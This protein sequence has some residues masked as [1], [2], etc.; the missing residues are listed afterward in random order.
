MTDWET[1]VLL[2]F[3]RNGDKGNYNNHRDLSLI[4]VT[5]RNFAALLLKK[6]QTLRSIQSRFSEGFRPVRDCID[7]IFNFLRVLEQRCCRKQSTASLTSQWRLIQLAVGRRGEYW[8]VIT[9]LINCSSQVRQTRI[10]INAESHPE[11]SPLRVVDTRRLKIVVDECLINILH[12]CDAD[13]INCPG[14]KIRW[15]LDES[16]SK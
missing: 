10:R 15:E 11:T 5:V 8:R 16:K 1:A 6:F 4:D 9:C 12:H 2:P 3:F 7:Q 14:L 13:R